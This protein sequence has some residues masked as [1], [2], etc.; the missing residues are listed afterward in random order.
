MRLIR[1]PFCPGVAEPGS[2]AKLNGTM[3]LSGLEQREKTPILTGSGAGGRFRS[4]YRK[5]FLDGPMKA[6][7]A[8]L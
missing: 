6:V 5:Q 3:E 4:D 8:R 1:T 2:L 7:K